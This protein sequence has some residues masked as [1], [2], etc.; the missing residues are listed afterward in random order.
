M[1]VSNGVTL[2]RANHTDGIANC[3]TSEH[4]LWSMGFDVASTT[5]AS[6]MRERSRSRTVGSLLKT[7]GISAACSSVTAVEIKGATLTALQVSQGPDGWHA[8]CVVDV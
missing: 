2:H 5:A 3:L 6:R 1:R 7:R 8:Q 4:G